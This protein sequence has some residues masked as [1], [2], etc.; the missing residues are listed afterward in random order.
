MRSRYP[1]NVSVNITIRAV[2]NEVRDEL[3]ARASRAGQSLQEF[4]S[5]ELT[6]I[7]SRPS[8]DDTIARIRERARRLPRVSME[9]ILKD[10]HVDRR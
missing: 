5:A 10:I 1:Q 8:V 3:A 9:Q 6:S 7:V 4:L 2:P